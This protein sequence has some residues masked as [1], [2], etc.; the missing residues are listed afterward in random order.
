MLSRCRRSQRSTSEPSGATGP[1]SARTTA[2]S[3]SVAAR[4]SSSS[5]SVHRCKIPWS[6]P[7]PWIRTS[8]DS[9]S[10]APPH[11][12]DDGITPG[13]VKDARPAPNASAAR[14]RISRT[15]SGPRAPE[16]STNDASAVTRRVSVSLV[17][18]ATK[19]RRSSGWTLYPSAATG[20]DRTPAPA[21][22]RPTGG[23]HP[24]Q[25]DP[26]GGLGRRDTVVGRAR[27]DLLERLLD[28]RE[29]GAH[30]LVVPA[31]RLLTGE[32][33]PP[34]GVRDVVGGVED[35]A[36]RQARGILGAG[37]LVVRSARDRV[38]RERGDRLPAKD[39]TGRARCEHVTGRC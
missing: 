25:G 31:R 35:V 33:D 4:S 29:A 37:E 22:S 38:A 32:P 28:R 30:L 26:I 2:A 16:A 23:R 10:G 36:R 17:P 18:V 6:S 11:T 5:G 1:D 19:Q 14:P 15:V 7:S 39:A 20:P 27:E 3:A 8:T 12:M 9:P 34:A 24:L 13:T 21:G